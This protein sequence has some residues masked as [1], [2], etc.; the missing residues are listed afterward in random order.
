MSAPPQESVL[1]SNLA[2]WPKDEST[3]DRRTEVRGEQ[4]SSNFE[5]SRKRKRRVRIHCVATA[6]RVCGQVDGTRPRAAETRG[7][8]GSND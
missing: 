5:R 8:G 3:V 1:L 2:A 4:F 6:Q 7:A